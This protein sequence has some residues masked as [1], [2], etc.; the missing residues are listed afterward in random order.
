MPT[1]H[2]NMVL[3]CVAAAQ[4]IM[5]T[6]KLALTLTSAKMVH[7]VA[8]SMLT[9]TTLLVRTNANVDVVTKVTAW[10]YVLSAMNA[11]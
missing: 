6:G 9:V 8:T 4:D 11:C 5:G 1:V 7:I 3:L 10:K 2:Y